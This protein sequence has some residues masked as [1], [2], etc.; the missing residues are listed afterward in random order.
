MELPRWGLACWVLAMGGK[1]R[2][3]RAKPCWKIGFLGRTYHLS[4]LYGAESVAL[5]DAH[6]GL[7]ASLGCGAQPDGT[8]NGTNT[9]QGGGGDGKD[10]LAK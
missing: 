5:E 10:P 3:V 9:V 1:G 8:H 6:A 7:R 4:I 2:G